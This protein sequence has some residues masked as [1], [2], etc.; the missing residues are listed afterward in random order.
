MMNRYFWT[1]DGGSLRPPGKY[2][3]I[4]T[5]SKLEL[6]VRQVL[7]WTDSCQYL[8]T[9]GQVG[10]FAFERSLE[11]YAARVIVRDDHIATLR[12]CSVAEGG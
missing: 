3:V 11:T 4:A 9:P 12:Q 8:G 5:L 6:E 2:P 10:I 7:A 1:G